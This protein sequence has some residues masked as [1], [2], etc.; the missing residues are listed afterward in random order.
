MLRLHRLVLAAAI[1][2]LVRPDAPAQEPACAECHDVDPARLGA[3]VHGPLACTDCHAGA[4]AVPHEPTDA[5]AD[6]AACHAEIVESLSGTPHAEATTCASCHGTIHDLRPIADAA[7]PAHPLRQPDTCGDCH[8]R[9]ETRDASGLAVVRPVEAYRHSVHAR[10]LREGRG[11]AACAS[12]HTAHAVLPPTDPRSTVARQNVPGTC[13]ACHAEIASEF[14]ASI[15]AVAAASGVRDAPV[16]TDCHGEHRI[17]SPSEPDS[18][19][20]ATNIPL[21]TCGRCHADV[22]LSERY[23]LPLDKVPAYAD[24][25]HGLASRAG[26]QSVAHCAS[27]HGVHDIRPSS[28]PRSD[29]HP[30]NLAATC[31]RCHP[32]AGARFAIGPVHV[33]ALSRGSVSRYVRLVYLP[34][35][36]L[37]VGAMLAHNLL[38]LLRKSREQAA[39]R[40]RVTG[41]VAPRMGRGF[42]IAHGLVA[43]SFPILA[44]TG[45]ALKYPEAWWARPILQ[46]ESSLGLRGWVHRVAAVLLTGALAFHVIHVAVDPRARRCIRG[47]LPSKDDWRELVA[48]VRYGLG[49]GPEPHGVKLGYVEKSEYWAFLWGTA[50]MALTGFALWFENLVLRWLPSAAAEVA[51]AIHFYEAILA[52][53]AILVW[54]LYWVVFDPRV[55]P[56]DPAWLTGR[57]APL[58]ARERGELEEDS[59]GPV[60]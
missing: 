57:A 29:V 26:T 48:R 15:H 20:F 40:E 54:H 6:C 55:Y 13:G 10:A 4:R 39:L 28:D 43:L 30:S 44:Y 33:T 25:Y 35:I 59:T 23:G 27:C 9:P 45:F 41:Q 38:D 18:P 53:L 2:V 19:T 16:C 14:A 37:V 3:S 1:V 60:D 51:T 11:G 8:A 50:L 17:L 32:G 46:W 34:L 31:G 47:M 49:R 5:R 52:T 21:Q 22:R 7:S 56:M 42:R 58:R 36:G 24:S 12:C